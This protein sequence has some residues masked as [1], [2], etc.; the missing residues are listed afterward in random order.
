[1]RRRSERFRLMVFLVAS[2]L[3]TQPLAGQDLRTLRDQV[4]ASGGRV[5]VR[6]KAPAGAG[7]R[8]RG[9]PVFSEAALDLK[10]GE[11]AGRHQFQVL[12]RA[13][14]L[15]TVVGVVS[16]ED[17][18]A[19]ATDPEVEMVEADRPWRLAEDAESPGRLGVVL[20]DAPPVAEDT[21]W[22]VSR[23]TAPEVWAMSGGTRGAGVKVAAMD[24]GGDIDHPDLLW[25]G[26]YNAIT[27]STSPSAWDDNVSVCN[28]HGTHVAGTIAARANGSG[29]IGVAP[30]AQ[31]YAIKVFE[32]IDGGCAAWTSTQV[33]GLNWAVQQ[34]IKVVSVSIGG[35]FSGIY[36]QAIYDARNAG[37]YLIA[38]AGNN[39]TYVNYPGASDFAI[40]V[41]ALTSTN[42]WA[43]YSNVGAQ[44]DFSAPGSSIYS[45]MP[46]GGYGYKSGTSM[47]TPHVS[48]VAALLLAKNPSLT[49]DGLY[50]ALKTGA[51]D[52]ET[53]GFDNK[54]GWGMVRAYN[55]LGG[56]GTPP[57][58]P[59]TLA[60]SP[61]SRSVSAQ[62]GTSAA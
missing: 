59:L 9:E 19:L 11:L 10:V 56:G 54:T 38:A 13:S 62:Q 25:A 14:A 31:L 42:N 1:M 53:G 44:I 28:G 50:A 7:L 60:V 37:T 26:G 27:K 2:A 29:V 51:L 24:S 18:A 46:G 52:V 57:P 61:G 21:P 30:E 48:G 49:F 6:F 3:A 41:G 39:G 17:A 5:L 33:T 8:A 55:S 40:G 12:G 47:A 45:T 43:S 32:V 22:G 15:A 4:T 58:V 20:A 36:E 34:G 23:V 16:P 35:S